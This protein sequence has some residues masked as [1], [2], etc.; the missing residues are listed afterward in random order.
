MVVANSLVYGKVR[1]YKCSL[2]YVFF[3]YNVLT[4]RVR[5]FAVS[6]PYVDLII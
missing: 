4:V 1:S 2:R 6:Y 3:L 5:Y